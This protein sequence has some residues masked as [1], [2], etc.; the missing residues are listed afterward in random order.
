MKPGAANRWLWALI[1]LGAL[2]ACARPAP[3]Q[4]L[5]EAVESVEAAIEGRDAGEL[6]R[7]LADDFIGPQGMDRDQARRTAMLYMMRY[8]SVGATLGPLEVALQDEDRGTVRFT[9]ALSGGSGRLVPDSARLYQVETG[10]R[11]RDGDWRM[12]SASW[13]PLIR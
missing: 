10:W 9:V 7:W 13:S 11:M 4:A 3:E 6:Q 12:T 2:A 5:R 8:Q 1:L